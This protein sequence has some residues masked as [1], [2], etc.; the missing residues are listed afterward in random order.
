MPIRPFLHEAFF[1]PETVE[2]LGRALEGAVARF[3]GHL[4]PGTRRAMA[5]L[6]ISAAKTGER[7]LERLIAAGLGPGPEDRR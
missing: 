2:L 4:L 1:D 7:D 6:I 3:K 5:I